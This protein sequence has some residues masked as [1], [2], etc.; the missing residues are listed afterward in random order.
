VYTAAVIAHFDP[1]WAVEYGDRVLL[2]LR[3]VMNPSDDDAYFPVFRHKDWYSGASSLFCICACQCH[4]YQ[5][6]WP[7]SLSASHVDA[8]ANPAG[9]SWASGI[10]LAGAKPFFNGRN[11][12]STSEAVNFYYA[13]AL[14]ARATADAALA[15]LS[16]LM[17]ATEIRGAWTYWQVTDDTVVYPPDFAAQ[18]VVGIMWTHLAQQQTWF[19]GAPY[20]VHGIQQLPSTPVNEWLLRREWVAQESAVFARACT[21][22]LSCA[23]LGWNTLVCLNRAVIDKAGAWECALAL[24]DANFDNDSAAGNGHSRANTYH[25]IATRP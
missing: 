14:W 9:H 7:L 24:P 5:D 25:W 22:D 2:M 11:Q 23:T 4:A 20:L 21:V 15:T 10:A 16:D 3:D 6:S 19:G 12:E 18:K 1:T 13:A 8:S 17:L